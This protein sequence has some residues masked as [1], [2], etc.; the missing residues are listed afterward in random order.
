M[1]K[2]YKEIDNYY[3]N[4]L[5]I[6]GATPRGVDWNSEDSQKLRFEQISKIIRSENASVNDL[7]CGYG[8]YIDFLEEKFSGFVYKGYDL[9]LDMIA[10]AKK[11]YPKYEFHKINSVEEL[12]VADYTVC[13]GI[14][15]VK[16]EVSDS[17]WLE[18]V[19]D[20]LDHMAEKSLNGFSFNMLT[21]YSDKEY[22]RSDL[23]YADPMLFF[24]HCKR[25]FSRNVAV[26]HDYDLYEFTVLVRN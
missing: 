22:M 13:S 2:V 8:K 12:V 15:S 11:Q 23:Y 14:F 18:Y 5:L 21:K 17:D 6:H 10:E 25:H 24:D 7:G 16:M 9:S 3:S 19:L 26:L 4:K 20:T 1:N